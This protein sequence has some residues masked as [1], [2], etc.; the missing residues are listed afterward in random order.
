M[1]QIKARK[2]LF[3]SKVYK[4]DFEKEMTFDPPKG[5]KEAYMS[6]Q[7]EIVMKGKIPF[8]IVLWHVF[9]D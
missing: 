9:T 3:I 1:S 7:P 2:T 4:V 8:Y 6:N 5:Y